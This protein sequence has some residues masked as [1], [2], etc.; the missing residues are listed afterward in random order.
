[1]MDGTANRQNTQPLKVAHIMAGAPTGGAELFFERLC[2]A[3]AAAG[4]SVLPV[5]RTNLERAQRLRAGNLA[6]VELPFG[7]MLDIRTRVGLRSA[8]KEFSPRVAVAWMN[9]A[10]RFAPK[11]NWVLAGRLGDFMTF[12]IIAAALILL[13]IRMAWCAGCAI[14]AGQ[15]MPCITSPTSPRIWRPHHPYGQIFCRTAPLFC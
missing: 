13:A 9:R 11:G 12:P 15:P 1:M 7:N 10:A 4:L 5:I 8:L 3:Q 14:K 2:I 6:P